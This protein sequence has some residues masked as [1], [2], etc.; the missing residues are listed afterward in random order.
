[1]ARAR[2][3]P[4]KST[5]AHHE[6]SLC[7]L[8]ALLTP[9]RAQTTLDAV[10]HHAW[11]ANTGWINWR[12]DGAAPAGAVTVDS[13][14]HGLIWSANCGW[15]NLGDGTPANGWHYANTTGADSGVN[16][17]TDGTLTGLAWGANIGWIVFEQ[18]SGHPR[19]DY[20]TGEFRGSAWSANSG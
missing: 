3:P 2:F 15:I 1:M 19:L 14:L 7:A 8:C 13:F 6:N 16:L 18:T 17:N 11:S 9:A 4:H 12:A 20:L 10:N 5:S